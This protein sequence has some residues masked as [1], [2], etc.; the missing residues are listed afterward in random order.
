[1]NV[2]FPVFICIACGLEAPPVRATE[3]GRELYPGQLRTKLK[4]EEPL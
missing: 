3:L 2:I 1:M 4:Q